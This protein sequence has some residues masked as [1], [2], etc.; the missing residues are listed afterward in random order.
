MELLTQRYSEKI[1]GKL[2][3]Y[4]RIVITG[5]LPVLSNDGHLTADMYQNNI[6]IFVYAKFCEPYR[7]EFKQKSQQKPEASGAER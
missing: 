4:E 1:S 3:C 2:S 5:T 7:D 6:R